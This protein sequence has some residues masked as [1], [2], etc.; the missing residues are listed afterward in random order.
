[1]KLD[2]EDTVHTSWICYSK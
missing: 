1:M 2:T